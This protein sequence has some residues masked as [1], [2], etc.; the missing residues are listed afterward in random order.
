MSETAALAARRDAD[1]ARHDDFGATAPDRFDDAVRGRLGPRRTSRLRRVLRRPTVVLSGLWLLVVLVAAVW[2]TLLAPGNPL[3]GVPSDNLL[4]PGWGHPLG[5][6][7]LGRD[8]YTRVVHGAGLTLSA[9]SLAV[10][11]GLVA[12]SVLGLVAGFVGGW[13]D[14]LVMRV[15]DVLLA[16]PSLLL[17]LAIITALGFGTVNVAIAVGIGSIASVARIMRSEVLRVRSSVYVEAARA[18]GNTWLRVL[19]R[20]VLPNSTGPVIVLAVLELGGAILAV[21]ALSFLGYGAQPP[22]PE[23]GALVAGGRDFLRGAWWLTTLPGVA[24][25]LTVLAANRLSRALDR[26]SEA[27]R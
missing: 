19:A 2:P 1:G 12:G 7:Q 26:E 11:V 16:I 15:A 20:H 3:D 21:S 25:A 8:L 9:A 24:I 5:T 10:A 22:D 14:S 27:V 4:P 17:S 6:D 18:A 13:L 23:W